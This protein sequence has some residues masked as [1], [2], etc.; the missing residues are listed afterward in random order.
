MSE[1]LEAE[2]AEAIATS[3]NLSFFFFLKVAIILRA[4]KVANIV[5][6]FM[7]RKKEKD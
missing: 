1:Q 4:W 5:P 2:I 7:G 6:S 3:C